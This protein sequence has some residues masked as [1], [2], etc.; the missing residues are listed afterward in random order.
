MARVLQGTKGRGHGL[1]IVEDF[2]FDQCGLGGRARVQSLLVEEAGVRLGEGVVLD[3]PA[4]MP[5][6][7]GQNTR[8][9][10]AG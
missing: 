5:L 6:W 8:N 3:D 1:R 2:L 7:T 9:T 10:E 4:A